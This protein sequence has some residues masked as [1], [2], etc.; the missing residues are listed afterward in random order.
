ML[1]LNSTRGGHAAVLLRL[2]RAAYCPDD[3]PQAGQRF[4]HFYLPVDGVDPVPLNWILS[5][6]T[7]RFTWDGAMQ[8]GGNPREAERMREALKAP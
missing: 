5:D 8:Q 1:G 4:F 7:A 2:A 6:S 3:S